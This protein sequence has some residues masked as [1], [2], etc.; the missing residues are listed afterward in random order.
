MTV[1]DEKTVAGSEKTVHGRRKTTVGSEKAVAGDE[2]RLV[3][4]RKTMRI[5]GF[6][7][8][9]HGPSADIDS[10][11]ST[12]LARFSLSLRF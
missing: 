3:G 8:V 1:G 12:S 5:R 11:R 6:R 4:G 9:F 10:C 2:K 7:V